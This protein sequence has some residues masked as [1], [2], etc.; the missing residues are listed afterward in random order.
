MKKLITASILVISIIANAQL[1]NSNDINLKDTVFGSLHI[2]LLIDS[3]PSEVAEEEDAPFDFNTKD[4][5][6]LGFNPNA[7]KEVLD[8]IEISIE[9]EDAEFDFDTKEYLPLG[10]N[11]NKNNPFSD[12]IEITIEEEDASFD[13]D[14]KEYLPKGFNPHKGLVK[15]GQ[16]NIC[17]L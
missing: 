12:I 11:P 5:L 2:D 17:S 9:E 8:L 7:T 1:S 15:K 3:L 14:T 13:F 6:P 4:Y 10:F 16:S